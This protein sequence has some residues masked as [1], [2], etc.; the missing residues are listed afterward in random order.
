M[1]RI[2]SLFI[3]YF[4]VI[5]L[6]SATGIYAQKWAVSNGNLYV[7]PIEAYVGIGLTNPAYHLDVSG[8]LNA[9][10]YFLNGSKIGVWYQ[11][12]TNDLYYSSGKVGIGTTT[13]SSDLSVAGEIDISGS[14]LHVG[15]NGNIGIGTSSPAA[16]LHVKG[17]SGTS[18]I[19]R[20]TDYGDHSEL[21]IHVTG[22]RTEFQSWGEAAATNPTIPAPLILNP[23]GGS[24][25]IGT[26]NPGSYKLAVNGSV[27]AKE[28]VVETGWSDFVFEDDYRLPPLAEVE[29]H[30]KT[31]KH[32]PDIP[33]AEEVAANGVSVGE[34]QARLLQKIEE[35][36]LYVIELKKENEALKQRVNELEN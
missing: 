22:S 6:L 3:F 8:Q 1:K 10:E 31:H 4:T 29:Q 14:R 33:S 23:S 19:M 15:T 13:P 17:I 5:S 27:H 30:I 20:L 25:G 9:S 16:R 12:P 7:D 11:T 26:T 18:E 36:T 24:V 2:H 34:M 32:L 21:R 35:L 28:V